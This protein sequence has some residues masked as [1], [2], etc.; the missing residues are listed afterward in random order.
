MI[1]YFI[2]ETYFEYNSNSYCVVLTTISC[3]GEIQAV[4][5]L[6]PQNTLQV[7]EDLVYAVLH[8]KNINIG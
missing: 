6:L 4:G 7:N 3:L 8:L 5:S 2:S 1:I